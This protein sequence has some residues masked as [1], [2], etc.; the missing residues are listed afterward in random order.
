[1]NIKNLVLVCTCAFSLALPTMTLAKDNAKKQ[2]TVYLC[3]KEDTPK[4]ILACNMYR[5][6]RGESDYGMLLIGFVTLNRKDHEKFP[7]TVR[8]I[9]YQPGQ[10]SWTKSGNFKVSE[11]DKWETARKFSQ[12]IIHLH[13]KNK[14]VYEALDPTKGATYYHTTKVNPYWAKSMTKTVKIGNHIFYKEKIDA[15]KTLEKKTTIGNVCLHYPLS[16]DTVF[17]A[18]DVLGASDWSLYA[19]YSGRIVPH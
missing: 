3:K 14:D 11:K 6:A 16:C 8:K 13:D 17:H 7:Q 15:P 19:W 10:F 5:E 12:A 4:N 2:K 9:V 18:M 1:M